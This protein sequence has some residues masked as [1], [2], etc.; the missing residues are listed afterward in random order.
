MNLVRVYYARISGN[1]LR[2]TKSISKQEIDLSR[3]LPI[4]Q[5]RAGLAKEQSAEP[6]EAKIKDKET[7]E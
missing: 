6:K 7:G 5:I 1:A 2:V 3:D 4:E